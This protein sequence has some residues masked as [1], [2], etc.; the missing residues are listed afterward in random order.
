MFTGNYLS[1]P[2][3]VLGGYGTP[4]ESG[5][6]LGPPP[7][8]PRSFG[9]LILRDGFKIPATGTDLFLLSTHGARCVYVGFLE[10]QNTMGCWC[11]EHFV[12][13]M[14]ILQ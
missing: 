8:P 14:Q 6:V 9:I 13:G 11:T 2:L 1:S 5:G 3:P 10:L 7:P 4:L 12:I